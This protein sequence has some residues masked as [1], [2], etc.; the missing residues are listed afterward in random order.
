ML[1]QSDGGHVVPS[2]ERGSLPELDVRTARLNRDERGLEERGLN[3]ANGDN[4]IAY[5]RETGQL[6]HRERCLS[7]SAIFSL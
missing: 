3:S 1:N 6:Y 2:V 7:D 4:E 5:T